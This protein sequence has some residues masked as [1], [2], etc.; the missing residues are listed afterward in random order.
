LILTGKLLF[1]VSIAAHIIPRDH[2]F[3]FCLSGPSKNRPGDCVKS[4]PGNGRIK[5]PIAQ[6]RNGVTWLH[7]AS[8]KGFKKKP[9]NVP[10]HYKIISHIKFQLIRQSKGENPLR[11]PAGPLDGWPSA[12]TG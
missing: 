5:K 7:V 9:L 6:T 1:P 12:Q 3:F 2:P 8:G 10:N 11:S 4:N